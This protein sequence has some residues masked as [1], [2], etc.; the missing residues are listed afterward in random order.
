MEYSPN[1]KHVTPGRRNL[2]KARWPVGVIY[3]IHFSDQIYFS[4]LQNW[5]VRFTYGSHTYNRDYNC[6]CLLAALE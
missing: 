4:V 2:K 6:Y 1:L 5:C 3:T